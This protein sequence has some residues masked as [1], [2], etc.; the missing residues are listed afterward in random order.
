VSIAK[1]PNCYNNNKIER[2]PIPKVNLY[3]LGYSPRGDSNTIYS[4]L[5]DYKEKDCWDRN[6]YEGYSKDMWL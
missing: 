3:K 2:I 5:G 1:C 4:Q 6:I